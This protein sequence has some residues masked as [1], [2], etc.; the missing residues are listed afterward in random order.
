MANGTKTA[1]AQVKNGTLI[2]P[3]TM[4]SAWQ[5]G[6]A[7]VFST[8]DML[9]IQKPRK[10]TKTSTLSKAAID[11]RLAK[12]LDDFT[13]D[14]AWGPFGSAQELMASLEHSRTTLHR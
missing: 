4:R 6:K 14:R 12:S 5:R 1:T 9:V 11:R 8:S 7:L 13:K 10:R 3:R 2:L